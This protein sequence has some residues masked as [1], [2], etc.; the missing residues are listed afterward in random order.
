MI[1]E[2]IPTAS[3]ARAKENRRRETTIL[4]VGH[5][6][7]DGQERPVRAA[8]A[9]AADYRKMPH[10]TPL[11]GHALAITIHQKKRT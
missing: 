4:A 10:R 9:S 3:A 1:S 5:L 8:A 6:I 11:E 7:G 2:R